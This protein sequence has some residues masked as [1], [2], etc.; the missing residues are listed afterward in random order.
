MIIISGGNS[1]G[2]EVYDV[3]GEVDQH[4][5]MALRLFFP[6]FGSLHIVAMRTAPW[7]LAFSRRWIGYHGFLY[8]ALCF[9]CK[10]SCQ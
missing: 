10:S 4:E 8:S 2:T 7:C 1:F 5:I 9:A 3:A 6:T